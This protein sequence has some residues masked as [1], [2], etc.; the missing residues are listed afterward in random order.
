MISSSNVSESAQSTLQPTS[1]ALNLIPVTLK[2]A[3]LDSPTYRSTTIHFSE[4]IDVIERWLE[5]Y[6]KAASRLAAELNQLESAVNGFLSHAAP[7]AQVS[8]AVLDHDYT[9]LAIRRYGE[10]ARE[11]WS[12][13]LRGAKKY[14]SGIVEPIK[15][16]LNNELRTFKDARRNVEAT[17]KI[18][19]NTLSR[20]SAQGKTKEASSL[21]EDAFQVHSVRTAYLKA[22]MDFC[23]AAPNLR[24]SL[25][26]L[27]VRIFS[28][29]WKDMRSASST[30]SRVIAARDV[31]MER[32]RGW[33]KDM[34]G[35]ERVFKQEL[36]TARR[37][38]EASAQ[39]LTRP[40]RELEDYATSTVPYLGTGARTVTG[41]A[42][43][44]TKEKEERRDKQ[45]WLFMRLSVG[46]SGARHAVWER[47]WFYVKNG[48]FGWLTLGPRSGGVE[49]S[50]RIGVLLCSVRPA[51]QE[52]RRFC[53]EVKT[54]D[55]SI[56]LQA[57]TQQELTGWIGAFE[58]AKRRAL[59]EPGSM[60]IRNHV[61]GIDPAFAITPPSAPEF[62]AKSDATA[63]PQ[64]DA[65][66]VGADREATSGLASTSRASFDVAANASQP[67][68]TAARRVLSVEREPGEGGRDH[69]ARIIQ[70]LDLHKRSSPSAQTNSGV[71]PA[72]GG[73]AGLIAA[74]HSILP[75]GPSTPI[76]PSAVPVDTSRRNFTATSGTVGAMANSLAPLTL[77]NPPAP[78]NLSQTAVIVSGE[79]GLELGRG[80]GDASGMPSGIMAN[81]WGSST[82]G[83]VNRIGDAPQRKTK[84][85]HPALDTFAVIPEARAQDDVGIMDGATATPIA[86]NPMASEINLSGVEAKHR[87]TLSVSN[88]APS[89]LLVT[90]PLSGPDVGDEYIANYP[91]PLRAQQAQFRMLFPSVPR[92][93]KVALVFRATWNPNEQQEFPGR[94]YATLENVYFY[95]NHLGL[96]LITGVSLESINDVTA[97]P[98]RDCDFLYLHLHE[99]IDHELR[100]ITVKV[101]LEP[102]RLLRRRLNY[103]VQNANQEEPSTFSAVL[104]TLIK[105]ENEKHQRSSSI[106]SGDDGLYSP[107]APEGAAVGGAATENQRPGTAARQERNIRTTL[108]IDGSLFD[109]APKTGRDVQRFKL[110]AQAVVYAPQ[111][112]QASVTRDFNVSAKAL[113]HVMFGDK[114]AVFQLLYSNR[115]ADKITQSPWSK[116]EPGGNWTRT[117]SSADAAALMH[118][119][120]CIEIYNDH[121]CYVVTNTK[122]PRKMPYAKSFTP[123]TKLVITHTA[124]SACKLVIFQSISWSSLPRWQYLRRLVEREAMRALEA[125]ALDLTTVAMDQ[126]SKLGH[127]SKTNRAVEIFGNVGQLGPQL[128]ASVVSGHGAGSSPH[129]KG[130]HEHINL[131][132][133]VLADVVAK[134]LRLLTGILDIATAV[135]K[136]MFGLVTGNTLLVALLA[137]SGLYNTWHGYRDTA[138]WYRERSAGKFMS[139]IGVRPDM[140]LAKVVYVRDLDHLIDWPA[141]QGATGN[142]TTSQTG[143]PLP[144]SSEATDASRSCRETFTNGVLT[145][146]TS[147]ADPTTARLHRTRDSLAR[148]RHDLLV[149]LRVVNRVEH[150]VVEA[151]YEDYVKIEARK[152]AEIEG[153]LK[154]RKRKQNGDKRNSHEKESKGDEREADLTTELGEAFA[155]YC[156][157]CQ[158]EV[159]NLRA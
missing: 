88:E 31:E 139:R 26:N 14:E 33:S 116:A 153:M 117:F 123:T 80:G 64:D 78:T 151:E 135:G 105:M 81:L 157:S 129:Q 8:E 5:G 28:E 39:D 22:S 126:V 60:D 66:P 121:L 77:A 132:R 65:A 119:T 69:A 97:A 144:D 49:E 10:G 48:I 13:T 127:H 133:M 146:S 115:W 136:G 7:P 12:S 67:Q 38:I 148:Y 140:N 103:L 124:K 83:N 128:N 1:R 125:D 63:Q 99:K 6:I 57:E 147:T 112:M 27:I 72:A 159:A 36:V 79:R 84:E 68:L 58:V 2:E 93:E 149:A 41:A 138:L 106:E 134:I 120:Q 143:L 155:A 17:Q 18:F 156:E 4:G 98:G 110:P 21:R 85:V 130:Q 11:F 94:V 118:D 90:T 46:R 47:R 145:T 87:K 158:S 113:F 73:I 76:T 29:Q 104:A 107:I 55:S 15:S 61:A 101:F 20:Y 131:P 96:V 50:D 86:I 44:A 3:A 59:E 54:N 42:N 62:A 137:L 108:R 114:S 82:W 9:M 53:F 75:V 52:E 30:N 37:Q 100:R 150:D 19:D 24:A 40:S 152:C 32:V 34:E 43:P 154:A 35:S 141:R 71:N 122:V 23:V 111:G 109:T 89:Q 45:S 56:I 25:D 51:F 102:L 142:G 92:T 95:S 70:K 91:L 16:F 74:S